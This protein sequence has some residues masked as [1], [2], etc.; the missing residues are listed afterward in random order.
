MLW[1]VLVCASAFQLYDRAIKMTQPAPEG[2]EVHTGAGG[3][4]VRKA[5][6]A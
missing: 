2:W 3:G 4:F 5:K 1:G 6:A